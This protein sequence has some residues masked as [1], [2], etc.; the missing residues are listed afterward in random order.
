MRRAHAVSMVSVAHSL[1]HAQEFLQR[2]YCGPGAASQKMNILG[3][4]VGGLVTNT[5]HDARHQRRSRENGVVMCLSTAEPPACPPGFGLSSGIPSTL[6]RLMANG[7]CKPTQHPEILRQWEHPGSGTTHGF[8][9]FGGVKNGRDLAIC[10]RYRLSLHR[11]C[12]TRGNAHL[13]SGY[14]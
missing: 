9:M 1:L 12:K 5:A 3:I 2:L 7:R 11:V 13:G 10:T 6:V 14:S 4:P 8:W